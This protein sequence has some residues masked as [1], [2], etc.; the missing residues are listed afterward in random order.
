MNYQENEN[1]N[2]LRHSF[3]V[4]PSNRLEASRLV[5]P[6]G[7]LYTPLKPVTNPL[8]LKYDPVFC[9]GCRSILN[10]YC[11]PNFQSK[12]WD[13]P[14]C[15]ARNMFPPAYHGC[16][17][18]NAPAEVLSQYTTI[19]YELNRP[20]G[21]PPI[22]LYVLDT[23]LPEEELSLLKDS[24]LM[25][26]NLLPQESLVGLITFGTTAQV[27]ELGFAEC[28]KAYVFRGDK[29][30]THEQVQDQ[31]GLR[32]STFQSQ[33]ANPQS[34]L[35]GN[36]N[37][38]T[39]QVASRFILPLSHCESMLT[40]IIEEL[41]VDPWP[42][43]P[44]RRFRRCTGV[45]IGIATSLLECSFSN[46]GAR[47]MSF[48]GGPCTL[49]D[50]QIAGLELTE[51]IRMHND[52][53]NDKAPHFKKA[54][55]YYQN[56]TQRLVQNGH[57]LDVFAACLDQVGVAE[58]KS[59]C[60]N[61]GGVLIITDT[62]ENEIYQESLKRLFTTNEG[63]L[64]MAFNA[65]IEVQVSQ[66]IKICGAIGPLTSMNVKNNHVSET[67]LG[68]GNTNAWKLNS[69]M[70]TSTIAF[71]FDIV[72]QTT[73]PGS[74]FRFFQYLTSYQHPS[75]YFRLRVTTQYLRW[76]EGDQNLNEIKVG[77][78]QDAAAVLISRLSVFKA[79]SEY[80]FDVLRWLDR[81]LIRLVTRFGEYRQQSADG[82]ALA[83]NFSLFPQF[84]YHL[85]RSQF[86]RVFNSSPDET[87][88]FRLW[89]NRENTFNCILMIQPT[90]HSYAAGQA[91]PMTVQLDSV[92]VRPNVILLLDTFFAVVVH[93]GEQIAGWRKAGFDQKPEFA[94]LKELQE[95]P[96]KDAQQLMEGRFPYPRFLECDEGGSQ[97]RFLIAKI[98]PSV[99]HHTSSYNASPNANN[100]VV[101][102]DDAS[103]QVFME[104]LKN[105]AWESRT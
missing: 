97:A 52:L 73:N 90:L 62:F 35:Q 96:V 6:V 103:M 20:P 23:C 86:L 93:H 84:M 44:K 9:K 88:F 77:F 69:L 5:L 18:T 29:S 92:S 50:G 37:P 16:S 58:M 99:T 67:E 49:G 14:I 27:Y 39:S 10:P 87:A 24:I 11:R 47:I 26:I 70:P 74:P 7:A 42:V 98:N 75:G 66:E 15:Q 53:R 91:Y 38:C 33:P 32:S 51:V 54:V 31:L 78:D 102:T 57:C 60:E 101:L 36:I 43:K 8:V 89:L 28:S 80:L 63:N 72:N 61:T 4:L 104:Y 13:C 48:L 79:E 46:S 55:K 94:Y 19:E 25:S 34:N 83:P 22:F 82:L 76:V 64:T 59:C 12:T 68:Y 30:P 17:E 105:L 40:T 81:S 56:L 1:Q 65:T 95:Q 41:Q 45:A 2:G 21:N 100:T 85:R 3:N 71:Y